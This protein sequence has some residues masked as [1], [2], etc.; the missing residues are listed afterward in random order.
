MAFKRLDPQTATDLDMIK[1]RIRAVPD[2]PQKG[3]L[4]R[5]IT[6]LLKDGAA[7]RRCI[8]LLADMVS[9][10]DFDYI[11]GIESRGFL[12]SPL[13]YKTE[14]GFLLVRKDGKLPFTK[15]KRNTCWN[16]VRRP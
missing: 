14:K 16:M 15:I 9:R 4:F 6:P 5:D 7:Y 11:A 10:Y 12:L 13:S 3:I 2:F 1:S 8:D